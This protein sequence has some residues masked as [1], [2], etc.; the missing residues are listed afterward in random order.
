MDW[1][2]PCVGIHLPASTQGTRELLTWG[3]TSWCQVL[4][5]VKEAREAWALRSPGPGPSWWLTSEPVS[6]FEI[7]PTPEGCPT[8]GRDCKD[9]AAVTYTWG[10]PVEGL[11]GDAE[12]LDAKISRL[13]LTQEYVAPSCGP[14]QLCPGEGEAGGS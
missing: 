3:E 14:N 10:S 5:K 8:D 4:P 9:K 2:S 11:R 1:A 12:I 6:L 13:E 7:M